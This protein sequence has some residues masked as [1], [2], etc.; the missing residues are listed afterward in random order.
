MVKRNIVIGITGA[1]GSIYAQRIL[2]YFEANKSE[3]IHIDIVMS[4]VAKTVWQQ[5]LRNKTYEEYSFRLYKN[6]N[7]Y[8]PFASGSAKYES[9]I[10][11]PSS[12][13]TIGRIANGISNDL[14][15]RAADVMLKE[16]K[17]L[18]IVPRESPI[19]LIHIKNMEKLILAGADIIPAMP[20]FFLQHA[21]IEIDSYKWGGA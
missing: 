18:I 20:S 13:G 1:S 11:I 14:I 12:M 7:F 4:D 3:H 6:S 9:L 8:A 2:D 15:S 10:I 5:E 19:N 17:K 16:R 21:D